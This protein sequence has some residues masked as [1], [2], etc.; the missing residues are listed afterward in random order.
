MRT[1][2]FDLIL[3]SEPDDNVADRLYGYFGAGGKAPGGVQT[4]VLGLRS[5]IPFA[6]CT[7]EAASFE[8]ALALVLPGL[9]A[10]G[11]AVERIEVD[12]EGLTVFEAA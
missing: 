4:V 11:L 12:R 9:R 5:G 8:E 7:V 10:E 1:Y 6:A 3:T 2:D